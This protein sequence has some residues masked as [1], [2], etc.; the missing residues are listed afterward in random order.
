M[1]RGCEILRGDR[2]L[3][4]H[5]G[6]HLRAQSHAGRETEE[7]GKKLMSQDTML[8]LFI[9]WTWGLSRTDLSTVSYSHMKERRL[10]QR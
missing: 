4:L 9:F 8:T 3:Q 7:N 10:V 1:D 5:D 2:E 6:D